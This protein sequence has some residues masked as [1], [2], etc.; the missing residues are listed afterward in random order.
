MKVEVIL[1]LGQPIETGEHTLCPNH[2]V[3]L[4]GRRATRAASALRAMLGQI[5]ALSPDARVR[6]LTVTCFKDGEVWEERNLVTIVV[7]PTTGA[8]T[9][10]EDAV[11]ADD[12]VGRNE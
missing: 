3:R 10:Q 11:D 1:M 6:D 4:N 7:R 5:V 12:P 8:D 2:A 9:E